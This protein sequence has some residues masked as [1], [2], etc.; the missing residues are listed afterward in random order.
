MPVNYVT[1]H[2]AL[3]YCDWLQPQLRRLAAQ[4]LAGGE[5]TTD[6]ELRFWQGLSE[7]ALQVSL[8]SEAE[9]ERAARGEDGRLFPWGNQADPN[10][11]NYSD[12]GLGDRSPVG[13]FPLGTSPL[14]CEEMSGNLWEWT[15]SRWGEYPY[16]ADERQRRER[17]AL[18]GPARRVLRGGAFNNNSRNVRCAF[19]NDFDPDDR[20]N[21]IGFRV[22]VSP[23]FSLND[24]AS[25][26]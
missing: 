23:S 24:E 21:L 13:C 2:D 10:H 8:P 3:A 7:G 14:G 26:L 16:P 9:W 5:E 1:W 4:R 15:R 11:A 18:S 17:E 22:V 6:A 20:L 25:E 12:S 19:R